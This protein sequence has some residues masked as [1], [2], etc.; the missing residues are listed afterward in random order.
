[1]DIG[2]KSIMPKLYIG[3]TDSIKPNQQYL[4]KSYLAEFLQKQQETNSALT[5]SIQMMSA[6]M[7]DYKSNHSMA[8]TE[9]DSKLT[10]QERIANDLV[11][12]VQNSEKNDSEIFSRLTHLEKLS[13]KIE[14]ILSN[15]KLMNEATIEQLA[16]LEQLTS[17]VNKK[18]ENFQT[19]QENLQEQIKQQDDLVIKVSEKLDIQDIFHQTMM[20]RFDK[21]EMN[22]NKIARQLDE[23]KE[24]LVERIETTLE[25]LLFQ[26]KNTVSYIK[27]LFLTKNR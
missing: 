19:V 22:T 8:F 15:E 18:L 12:G 13:M 17:N 16:F 20:E 7:L 9:I 10:S 5:S 4:R 1:M 6:E 27:E 26:Y 14:E 21:Q 24:S 25:S 23:L 2:N 3:S 11:K